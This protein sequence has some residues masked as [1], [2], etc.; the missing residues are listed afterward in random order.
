[1]ERRHH[2]RKPLTMPVELL[3]AEACLLGASRDVGPEG[4][5]LAIPSVRVK[6]SPSTLLDTPVTIRVAQ[7][8]L[9][10]CLKWYTLDES[11]FLLG[12]EVANRDRAS[13]L[14]IVTRPA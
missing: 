14:A 8:E 10:A 12:L 9:G 4:L 5:S 1:M 2:K 6:F 11:D 7:Q 13:W 3:V